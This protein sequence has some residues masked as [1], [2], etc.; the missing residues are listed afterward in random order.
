MEILEILGIP[1]FKNGSGIHIKKENRGKFT[2]YCDGKVTQECIDKA[3]KSNN[4][5][6]KKRATFAENSRAWKH[7]NGGVAQRKVNLDAM[8]K[9]PEWNNFRLYM[10]PRNLGI[11]VDSLNGRNASDYQLAG[12]LSN[13]ISEKGGDTDSH[14]NGAAGLAGWRGSRAINLPSDLGGQAH[15]LMVELYDNPNSTD[16]HHGGKGSGYM[17]ASDAHQSFRTATSV[18]SATNAMTRGYVRPPVS[19]YEKR[20]KLAELI[21]KYIEK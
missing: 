21:Y 15:K 6:L 19:E 2:E 7:Q 17:S 1:Y 14:G 20:R 11:V 13:I 9:D 10:N 4:P 16:W 12:V 3:K 18:G 5:T 8:K